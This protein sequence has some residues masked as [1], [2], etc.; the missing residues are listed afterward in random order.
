MG[1]IRDFNFPLNELFGL[2]IMHNCTEYCFLV[3]FSTDNDK[4]IC[5]GSGAQIRNEKNFDSPVFQRHSWHGEFDASLI[6][7]SDP[8]FLQSNN[9]KCGWCVGTPEEYYLIFIKEIIEKLC[10]NKNIKNENILFYGS[11]AGGFTSIQLGTYFKGSKVLV[12]NPQVDVRNFND[13]YYDT[14]LNVCFENMDKEVVEEKFSERLDVFSTFKK[15]NYVP[16]IYYLL[17]LY[18]DVDFKSNF[19]PFLNEIKKLNFINYIQILIYNENGFHTPINKTKTINLINYLSDD[20][21]ITLDNMQKI[22]LVNQI[23]FSIPYD[24]DDVDI[25]AENKLKFINK[26]NEEIIIH[27]FSQNSMMSERIFNNQIKAHENDGN[28]ILVK[29]SFVINHIKV[30]LL[31][32]QDERGPHTFFYFDNFNNSYLVVFYNFNSF[33]HE[34]EL[35]KNIVINMKKEKVFN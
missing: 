16:K 24:F 32:F 31:K 34:I 28:L 15:E 23:K 9:A 13:E 18:S 14:L 8:I 27:E 29:D 19:I 11:S 30:F 17:E 2:K 26:K 35:I 33:Y 6:Y 22:K 1:D 20:S 25:Q 4:L 5:L 7:Y 21:L 10:F 12:N 3:R